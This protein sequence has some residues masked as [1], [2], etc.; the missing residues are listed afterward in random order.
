MDPTDIAILYALYRY[1]SNYILWISVRYL[2]YD[3]ILIFV[4][5]VGVRVI[6]SRSA[7]NCRQNIAL[8]QPITTTVTTGIIATQTWRS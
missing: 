3:E 7:Q 4:W 6:R 5:P 1:D 8:N 2:S